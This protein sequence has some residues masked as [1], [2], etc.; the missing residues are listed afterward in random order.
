MD[1]RDMRP[2]GP[3][4]TK[5]KIAA[6]TL[7]IAASSFSVGSIP[8]ACASQPPTPAIA[9]QS[10]IDLSSA[11][12]Q[13]STIRIVHGKKR[14]MDIPI[15]KP[16]QTANEAA[17]PRSDSALQSFS[18]LLST[19][20]IPIRELSPN[21]LLSKSPSESE[22]QSLEE[23]SDDAFAFEAPKLRR[24]HVADRRQLKPLADFVATDELVLDA[25]QVEDDRGSDDEQVT[26]GGLRKAAKRGGFGMLAIDQIGEYF[27]GEAPAVASSDAEP[28][29]TPSLPTD[30]QLAEVVPMLPE[31]ETKL[32]T[33]D[34]SNQALIS[35][36]NT[37]RNK[38][39]P[40]RLSDA[41]DHF[42]LP[43]EL[44]DELAN[45]GPIEP[46]LLAE[47]FAKAVQGAT[48]NP[49]PPLPKPV[50]VIEITDS[51]DLKPGLFQRIF[52]TIK[53]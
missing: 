5:R 50:E 13:R 51:G 53:R 38:L 52:R 27:P 2:R 34:V 9:A 28:T 7:A 39:S 26:T 10:E 48:A 6:A 33:I 11:P 17:A 31:P 15:A 23:V 49:D 14:Y 43:D 21:D 29:P 19:K 40:I 35:P 32:P 41:Q 8:W 24:F 45:N 36:T 22:S 16:T 25:L 30:T 46:E 20:A 37:N 44:A 42:T 12:S 18:E 47:Q 4:R 3:R 1:G